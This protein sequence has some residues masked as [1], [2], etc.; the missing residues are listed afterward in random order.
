MK[1]KALIFAGSSL[2]L[3]STFTGVTAPAQASQS[4]WVVPVA[5]RHLTQKQAAQLINTASTSEDHHLL[6]QYFRHEA[7]RK[8]EKERYYLET[9]ATYRL[10]PLRVDA[11]R[12]VSTADYYKHL[13]DEARDFALADDQL[14]ALHDKLAE[15]LAQPK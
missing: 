14:A 1:A 5:A 10:H 11:Y 7:Q 12:N 3:L 15:D 6:A 4:S 13:A 2:L 9:S 8:R